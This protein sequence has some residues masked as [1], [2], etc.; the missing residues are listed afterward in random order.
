V[1][2]FP[3]PALPG[4]ETPEGLLVKAIK[5]LQE[6]ERLISAGVPPP[7]SLIGHGHSPFLKNTRRAVAR[8]SA[9]LAQKLI[10]V[11]KV[12]LLSENGFG[13]SR[14]QAVA[15]VGLVKRLVTDPGL[16]QGVETLAEAG[17]VADATDDERRVFERRG[18]ESAGSLD[19]GMTGLHHL[20]RV[21]QVAPDKN[22]Q[23]RT[24]SY[25]PELHENL[26]G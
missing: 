12:S 24:V 5:S 20:L 13:G 26:P 6:Q 4:G 10:L 7:P 17:S 25:L 19:G 3:F 14:G 18:K 1:G 23:V 16:I 8:A 9:L 2:H 21:G 11:K 22:V 15:E